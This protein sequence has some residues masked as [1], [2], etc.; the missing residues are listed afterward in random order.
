MPDADQDVQLLTAAAVAL[1][2][3]VGLLSELGSAFAAAG[4]ELYLVGGSVRDAL[5]GR[6]SPDLDFTTDA[7]P[8]QV[9][10][11]VRSWADAI[12]ETGIEFGTVGV[13]KGENRLEITTFRADTYDQV[14]R[15]PEVQFGDRLEDDLVRRDFTVNAMAVRITATGPGEFLDPLGGLGA[16]RAKVL[17]TPS[18]PEVSFGDDPLRM[19]RA[20]RFVSQLGFTVAPRVRAA[21]EDM[22]P[23]L[24]RISAERVAAELDKM[25]LGA[26]PVAGIDLLVQTGMGEVVLP[27]I[28]GMQMAI[29][30]HHQ[31]KD[32]Y[33]H[34][35]TVLRQAIALEDDGP[36][37]VLRWAALLHD[38]GKPATRRHEANGG[39]SFHHH[40]VVGAKMVRKRMRALKYSKQMVDDVSQL[41]YLHLRFHGYGEGKWTDSAVRRYVTDAGPLLPRLH[42]LVRADCTT[43]NK[44]RAAR[45]QAS[46]DRL[47][48]RIAEL[49]AKEDLARV[50]PDLDGNEIMQLLDIPAGPVV[51]EAWKFL[52]EL[53]LD[54]G[55]LS[56]E[57]ATQELLAWWEER[58]A[59]NP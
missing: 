44:R 33:Q 55:P 38:I 7:R 4:H 35:L 53:R 37:L 21:I 19:L 23:Q 8:E 49:A 17:D 9:Q 16:L 25:M 26:D 11:I 24:A 29:D 40:E 28:G 2:K 12:W 15:N 56:R 3:H 41:V 42:K 27:E 22:A 30:E 39:V 36:D 48:E 45:L 51:G 52:K 59:R 10:K 20:A 54:R 13:G 18:S 46:Y 34:S 31:H 32:V 50:R 43:R 6:L 57:E 5:L 58:K 14:S 47:E 1:N